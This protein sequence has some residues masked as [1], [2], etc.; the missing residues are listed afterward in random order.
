MPYTDHYVPKEGTQ[1]FNE[2]LKAWGDDSRP[3]QYAAIG[4][5]TLAATVAVIIRLYAQRVYRKGWGL[6]DLFILIA[7]VRTTR[8]SQ[9]KNNTVSNR[10]LVYPTCRVYHRSVGHE[11]RSWPPPNS[12]PLR[13]QSSAQHSAIHLYCQCNDTLI[14]RL[15]LTIIQNYWVLTVLWAPGVTLIKLSILALYH[16]LFFVPQRWFRIALWINAIYSIALGIATTI[17]FILQCSPVDYY[18]TRYASYYGYTLP[19][20]KCLPNTREYLGLPQVLSTLSDLAILCLPIPIIWNLI[21]STPRKFA[22][23]I[24]FL[25]GA[26]TVGCGAV[27]IAMIFKMDSSE[28]TTVGLVSFESSSNTKSNN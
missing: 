7:M 24:A 17:V 6:D 22:V 2:Q 25:L 21:I 12:S 8:S 16:R 15:K 28:D 18:W 9:N 13:R 10:R 14:C 5:T 23:S 11:R 3:Q 20:G 4:I 19:S 26:F 1:E 27:R